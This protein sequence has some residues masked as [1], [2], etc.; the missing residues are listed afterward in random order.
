MM[1]DGVIR[2]EA[3][4]QGFVACGFA[5]LGPSSGYRD[6]L[7]WIEAGHA[8][9]MQY[10]RRHAAL[11]RNP[12]TL[13]P[14]AR[15]IIAV[16]A[17]YPVNPAPRGGFSTYARGVDYHDVLRRKLRAI[18]ERIRTAAAPVA[19]PARICIDSA[20]LLEREWAARAGLGWR[21]RQGQLVNAE[22]G[23]CLVLGFILTD[24]DLPAAPRQPNQCRDCRRCLDACP[25]GA[26]LGN[27]IVD[28]RR[29]LSYL[30][31][32]HAG[33][34]PPAWSDSLHGAL[35]G[36]DRCTAVCPYNPPDDKPGVM[37]ELNAMAQPPSAAELMNMDATAFAD[38]FRGTAVYRSGLA[39]LQRNAACV[40]DA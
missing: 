1:L 27:G 28:A 5:R 9:G 18:V 24:L 37:P 16:A 14:D 6:Y 17:R 11:R 4:R 21:G 19:V 25:T 26:A 3:Q 40:A 13:A 33:A 20:P 15:S 30:T 23:A 38:R 22:H 2:D 36:C 12:R 10:L 29:C 35:F 8:A 31:I 34:I 7:Q 39:R 32:E